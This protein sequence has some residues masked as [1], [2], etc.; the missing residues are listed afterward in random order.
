MMNN[1]FFDHILKVEGGWSDHKNDAGGATMMGITKRTYEAWLGRSVSKNELRNISKK[2]VLDIYKAR[3]YDVNRT[4]QLDNEF[5]RLALFDQAVNR[6]PRTGAKLLQETCNLFGKNLSVDGRVGNLTLAAANSIDPKELGMDFVQKAQHGYVNIVK[7][8]S[9]QMVFLSGWMNRTHVLLDDYAGY[10]GQFDGSMAK[11]PEEDPA[12]I[13]ELGL[14][15]KIVKHNPTINKIGLTKALSFYD[16]PSVTDK[17]YMT[18]VDFDIRSSK[19]RMWVLNM[20]TGEAIFHLKVAHGKYSDPNHDGYADKYSNKPGS[21]QSSLGAMVVGEKYGS[22]DDGWSKFP[23]ATK[24]RGIEPGLNDNVYKRA[25]VFHSSKYV[26]QFNKL[27]SGRSLGCFA[28]D[29][30]VA[31]R[32]QE[33]IYGGTLLYAYD[34]DF[35]SA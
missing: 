3:Y 14:F 35:L 21:G 15:S 9:S 34:K 2:E 31:K 6:G 17:K 27:I 30:D 23:V 4:A 28:V 18:F 33:Y 10:V 1:K 22:S 7:S 5:V 32:V 25:V 26:N 20:R 19:P 12:D 29:D 16:H 11:T 24:L 13:I 8:K